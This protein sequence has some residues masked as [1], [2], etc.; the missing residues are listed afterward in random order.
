MAKR[1]L[2]NV[3]GTLKNVKR[4]LVNVNG[5]LKN[6]KSGLV[7]VNG[8]L[9]QF[10]S[11]SV[12]PVIEQQVQLT[13]SSAVNADYHNSTYP[14]TLT[15]RK[16]HFANA[17]VFSY[18][19]YRSADQV[20]WTAMTSVTFTSNPSTGSSST[21]TYQLQNTDFTSTT[22][23]FK[24]E[25][26]ANNSG[27]GTV[28]VSTSNIVSVMYLDIPAPSPGFPNI[29]QSTIQVA[30][31]ASS[32]TWIG[33]P[34]LYDWKW[35]YGTSNLTLTYLANKSITYASISGTTAS[36][37]AFDHG[38]KNGDT[39]SVSGVN[40]LYNNGGSSINSILTNLF[41]YSISKPAWSYAT[42]YFVND[43][44]S[45][46]G[47]IYRSAIATPART[48]WSFSIN[49]SAGQYV[50]YSNQLYQANSSTPSPRTTWNN[51]TNYSVGQY[52]NYGGQVWQSTSTL[53]GQTPFNGSDFWN[54]INIYPG[55]SYW[56]L[57]NIY[58]GGSYWELQSG[59]ISPSG[60][61]ASGPNY[62]EGYYSS[63]VSYTISSFPAIDYKT[64]TSLLGLTTRLNVAAYNAAFNGSAN[65]AARTIFGYP[66]FFFGAQTITGT[67]ASIIYAEANMSVY[68][69]DVKTGGTSISGYP[70]INQA[71]SSPISITG[72][73]PGTT[74]NVFVTPK[75][76]D[77]PRASGDQKTT[78]FTTPNPPGT[79]TITFS[80]INASGFTVSWSAS[81]ATSYN[82]DIKN[83]SSGI[84]IGSGSG[85]PPGTSYPKTGT[86]VTS[87]TLTGLQPGTNYTVYVTGVNSSG[88][89]PQANNNQYTNVILSYNGNNNTSGSVPSQ[90]QFTYNATAT[91]QGN[92]GS[93]ART[94]ATWA[95]W[96]LSSDGSG[97]VYGPG[98]TTTIQMNQS[99]TLF[100]K[101]NANVPGAPTINSVGRSPANAT[102]STNSLVF[103]QVNFGAD[104]QNVLIEWGTTL[105]YSTGSN[106]IT[107][108]GSSY[109][110]PATLSAN[111]TYFWRAR[112]Y[113]PLYNGYGSPLTGSVAI[114]AAQVAPSGGVVGTPTLSSGTNGRIGSSYAVNITTEATGTAT[115]T[116]SYQWQYYNNATSSWF[117]ITGATST[118]YTVPYFENSNTISMSGRTIR[119]QVTWTNSIG[120]Q[121]A[122]AASDTNGRAISIPTITGVTATLSLTAPFI[123]YRVY[124][125]N[126]QS[127]QSKNSFGT[128]TPP[129]NTDANYTY[130]QAANSTIPIT[131]QSNN[132]GDLNY[133]RLEAAAYDKIGTG[134]APT[135]PFSGGV[136]I[137]TTTV[138]NNATNRTNSP[139]N[140]FGQGST[141][142]S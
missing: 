60:G 27:F 133:Y 44:V 16:Y 25:Y 77:S 45:Y 138:R 33:N 34:I 122:P 139:I 126:F 103:T 65:S 120:S 109:T 97:T 137:N 19:F 42:Q 140:V 112:G 102:A 12:V 136:T 46:S 115:I 121:V 49:Y 131:R 18:R 8:I 84:S 66:A 129:T 100:A 99:R 6:V 67:T 4:I 17:D 43:Y 132:G 80:S 71:N 59:T 29:N 128:T 87:D 82:V 74:Y 23:Y 10:F 47:S 89:G 101:W 113:N 123:V 119:C 94:Y 78:S 28:G 36:I 130:S 61:V 22:M 57:V 93:L 54:L 11:T 114:P 32:G 53:S 135:S 116:K 70:K 85:F 105:A 2:V 39:V 63:P 40:A 73:S 31:T 48:A 9:K 134:S 127:I 69:I 111:T 52:V 72:L 38:F 26:T 98:F 117:S 79:P 21:V 37:T 58:P 51:S 110:T 15:G 107:T 20:V 124:G 75:N 56:T 92:T 41:S 3:N 90:G 50:D 95:G 76:N 104:T 64:G 62:H 91:V 118:S 1:L 35:Q 13:K 96:T 83:T 7:N 86:A 5:I 81:G 108:S 142:P 68:D 88:S 24:F 55:G 30:S 14:V 141:I 106:T 125:Y